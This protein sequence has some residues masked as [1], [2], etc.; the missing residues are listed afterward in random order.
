V[1]PFPFSHPSLHGC[2]V[3]GT[4]NRIADTSDNQSGIFSRSASNDLTGNRVANSF[5]GMLLQAGGIGRGES[6]GKVCEADARFGRLE[7]NTFHGHGRF[8]T[9]SLGF[10]YPKVT[11]QSISSD[12]HNIDNSLCEG[13]DDQG[14]TRGLPVSIVENVDYHNAFVGHYEAGGNYDEYYF[15]LRILSSYNAVAFDS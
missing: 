10:N 1:C 9:Y 4:S 11:D 7:G 8:G 5:N 14:N 12:G 6:Y 3:P 13:F 15:V 2:T